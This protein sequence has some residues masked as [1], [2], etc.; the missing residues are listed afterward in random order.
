MKQRSFIANSQTVSLPWSVG[1]D[2]RHVL[3]VDSLNGNLKLGDK[4][5]AVRKGDSL[6]S[7]VWEPPIGDRQSVLGVEKGGGGRKELVKW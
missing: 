6:T 1:E 3:S 5:M 2:W 4:W 7:R